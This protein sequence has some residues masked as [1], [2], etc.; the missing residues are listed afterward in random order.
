MARLRRSSET[1]SGPSGPHHFVEADNVRLALALSST[2]PDYAM[3][4]LATVANASVRVSRC[5]VSGC[6]RPRED[7]IHWPSE[8][9]ADRDLG[10]FPADS[11]D[12]WHVGVGLVETEDDVTLQPVRSDGIA[13]V[14]HHPSDKG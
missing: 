5:A 8:P 11:E 3:V 4:S 13:V 12:D 10:E 14:P 2:Q 6:G 1:G 7:P 9:E